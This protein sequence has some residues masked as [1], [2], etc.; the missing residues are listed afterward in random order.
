MIRNIKY[1]TIN[2]YFLLLALFSVY[3]IAH[4]PALYI[5]YFWDE[6]WVYAP[7]VQQMASNGPSLLPGVIDLEYS[8]GHPL[9]FHFIYGVFLQ[10]MGV[11]HFS[12]H[13][14]ALSI[15]IFSFLIIY[16]KTRQLFGIETALTSI[17]VLSTQ[18]IIFAQ[19]TLVLPEILLMALAFWAVTSYAM[20][21]KIEFMMDSSLA[22]LV[23]ES[24]I[25]VLLT[26]LVYHYVK[27]VYRKEIDHPYF[28]YVSFCPFCLFL[29]LQFMEYGWF[30][31]PEHLELNNLKWNIFTEKLFYILDWTF[32][33]RGRL[34]ITH[35]FISC[36]ILQRFKSNLSLSSKT[37]E[38]YTISFLL[39][40]FYSIFSATNFFTYRYTCLLLPFL[41]ISSFS[42]LKKMSSSLFFYSMSIA[43][44]FVG[45]G[46][47]L[48]SA[49]QEPRDMNISFW[50]YCSTQSDAIKSLEDLD[51]YDVDIHAPNLI[52]HALVDPLSGYRTNTKEFSQAT[53]WQNRNG[54][55]SSIY[56][57]SDLEPN[58]TVRRIV[59]NNNYE[60]LNTFGTKGGLIEI[61]KSK[62]DN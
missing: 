36:W 26:V 19:S 60:L 35:I 29:L 15:S 6:S 27:S 3:I 50:N 61:Y 13:V 39:I 22:L 7:A 23:K 43:I 1:S 33:E 5:P 18:P 21:Q 17:L 16:I 8:R 58:N 53:N 10:I 34:I 49:K 54:E 48:S 25:V 57:T 11:S 40:A 41:I 44:S 9:L 4:L 56:I 62:K 20:N 38:F 37:K 52:Y 32:V 31:Y 59:T 45:F 28:I 46:Y 24:F 12:L 14:V 42:L 55:E 30:F 47:T 2:Q 51:I